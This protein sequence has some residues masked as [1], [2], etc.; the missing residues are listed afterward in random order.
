MSEVGFFGNM[1]YAATLPSCVLYLRPFGTSGGTTFKDFSPKARAMSV[2]GS[3]ANSN[4]QLKFP[5]CSI[6]QNGSGGYVQTTSGSADFSLGTLW[7]CSMWLYPT[8]TM[9]GLFQIYLN[10][11]NNIL[12][13]F[14][15]ANQPYIESHIA[16]SVTMEAAWTTSSLT[17]N[18]WHH[19]YLG[20]TSASSCFFYLDGT[21]YNATASPTGPT[22]GSALNSTILQIGQETTD[23]K[24][25]TG[26]FDEFAIWNGS[27][28]NIPTISMLYPQTRRMIV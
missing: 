1:P 11:G 20:Q 13:A 25:L 8:T 19:F 5:P 4:T 6:Y 15:S 26:Y 9:P 10:S 28:G 3:A 16:S 17:V 14:L 27:L 7:G 12:C 18:A 21:L 23:S 24:Y 2:T 22:G